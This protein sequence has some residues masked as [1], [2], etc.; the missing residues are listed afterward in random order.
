M[1]K[2]WYRVDVLEGDKTRALVGTSSLPPADFVRQLAG[3]DYFVLNDLSYRDNQNRI[4]P[5][6]SWDPRLAS[7]IYV[8]PRCVTTVTPF[9][10]D[11][12]SDDATGK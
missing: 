8:N 10:G 5:F 9:V 11:P 4:V 7:V 3:T 6:S 1:S 12:T 2:F